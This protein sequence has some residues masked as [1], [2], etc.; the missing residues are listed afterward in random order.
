[1]Y[2]AK[3]FRSFPYHFVLLPLSCVQSEGAKFIF[4]EVLLMVCMAD[5]ITAAILRYQ[6][7]LAAMPHV[8]SGSHGTSPARCD[9]VAS[10]AFLLHLFS[11]LADGIQFLKDVSL[12]PSQMRCPFCQSDMRFCRKQNANRRVQIAVPKGSARTPV[13]RVNQHSAFYVVQS[14]PFNPSGGPHPDIPHRSETTCCIHRHR[15]AGGPHYH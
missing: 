2:K 11:T 5:D 8:P 15:A 9:G 6:R 1:V 4:Q 14:Q 13:Q 12:L 7:R 10:A 3:E